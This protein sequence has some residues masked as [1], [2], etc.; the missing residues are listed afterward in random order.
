[1]GRPLRACALEVGEEPFSHR[2]LQC[3]ATL[4]EAL[5]D[6]R[7]DEGVLILG[8]VTTCGSRRVLGPEPE[9]THTALTPLEAI[10]EDG[11][12]NQIHS[13]SPIRFHEVWD[14]NPYFGLGR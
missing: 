3:S 11:D 8:G 9:P 14:L 5:D 4:I 7:T 6:R 12:T 2:I 10:F 13:P 1:M